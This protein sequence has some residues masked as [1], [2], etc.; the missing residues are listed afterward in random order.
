MFGLIGQARGLLF[1]LSTGQ[2]DSEVDKAV[3]A[4]CALG[5]EKVAERIDMLREGGSCPECLSLSHS[6]RSALLEELQAIMAVYEL[7]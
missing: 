5:C 1:K 2:P 4:V 7:R 3:D 6:Q